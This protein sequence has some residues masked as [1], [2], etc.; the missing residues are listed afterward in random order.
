MKPALTHT[1]SPSCLCRSFV[2]ELAVP[3]DQPQ[4]YWV[5]RGVAFLLSL[6]E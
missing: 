6:A 5:R 1:P 3:S 4:D 2:M